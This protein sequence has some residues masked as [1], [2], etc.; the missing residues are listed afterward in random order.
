M[1]CL[2]LL[3]GLGC[4]HQGE[5]K[6]EYYGVFCYVLGG[7]TP[8]HHLGGKHSMFELGRHEVVLF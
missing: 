1:M 7:F 4:L 2:L 8:F 5:G 6:R 3:G